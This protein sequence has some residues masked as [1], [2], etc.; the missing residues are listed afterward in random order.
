[1]KTLT[2]AGSL[3]KDSFNKKIAQYAANLLQDKKL[4]EEVTYCDLQPLEIPVYDG[5][6]EGKS[7]L[8]LGVVRLIEHITQA[9]ALVIST[10]EYNGSI[11]GVLKNVLDWISRHKPN[12]LAGKHVLLLAASPGTLGGIR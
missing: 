11:P 5:D 1:M 12:P 10:P 6:V 2:L 4:S 9:D 3:R 7:G 8:P